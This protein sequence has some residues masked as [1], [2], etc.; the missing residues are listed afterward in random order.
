MTSSTATSTRASSARGFA[1]WRRAGVAA[2]G[3]ASGGRACAWSA[4]SCCCSCTARGAIVALGSLALVAIYPFMKRITWW[5]QAWLG[6]VFSLGRAGRLA[7]GDR[8]PRLAAL[9]ALAW[10]RGVGLGYDT[11]YA[12]QDVE[13]D[14]LVG[15]SSS[16]PPAWPGRHPWASPIHARCA[17]VLGR[18]HLVSPSPRISSH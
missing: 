4:S 7:G 5:P 2:R 8:R 6:L 17:A 10:Q 9:A 3:V 11:L 13:D 14:A 16:R 15:C 12:I 18:R 1:R